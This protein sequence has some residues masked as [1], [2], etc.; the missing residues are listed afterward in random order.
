MACVIAMLGIAVMGFDIPAG[1]DTSLEE[2]FAGGSGALSFSQGELLTMGAAFL[3]TFHIV[4]IG[5]YSQTNGPLEIASTKATAEMVYSGG[6]VASLLIAANMDPVDGG[7]LGLAQ[8]YG[9]ELMVFLDT[10]QERI[11]EHSLPAES[12]GKAT[13]A[14]LW[15]GIVATAYVVFAQ[16]YG[17]KSVKATDANLIYSLQPIFTA[18]FAFLLLGETMEPIGFVGASLIGSAVYLVASKDREDN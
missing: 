3:Y 17:Q 1:A 11:A 10:V 12:I 6:L 16:A 5:H 4:R 15:T 18:L 14:T 2:L 9:Q 13:F 8:E 7:M